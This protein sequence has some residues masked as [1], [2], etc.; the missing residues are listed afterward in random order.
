[1]LL[2]HFLLLVLLP[3]I[4]APSPLLKVS[5]RLIS[6]YL[7]DRIDQFYFSE[8][9]YELINDNFEAPQFRPLPLAD[10]LYIQKTGSMPPNKRLYR[11]MYAITELKIQDV[12]RY[13][14][15]KISHVDASVCPP[16]PTDL[17][18][19]DIAF[20]KFES[21]KVGSPEAALRRL[22]FEPDFVS[23]VI[24]GPFPNLQDSAARLAHLA[25]DPMPLVTKEILLHPHI[26]KLGPAGGRFIMTPERYALLLATFLTRVTSENAVVREV[27]DSLSPSQIAVLATTLLEHRW[28]KGVWSEDALV[29]LSTPN[30]FERLEGLDRKTLLYQLS[31]HIDGPKSFSEMS[32][33]NTF[34]DSLL[35]DL[36]QVHDALDISNGNRLSALG[37]SAIQEKAKSFPLLE[38]LLTPSDNRVGAL[39]Y[40]ISDSILLSHINSEQATK[41]LK[42]LMSIPS[43]ASGLFL[44]QSAIM[45]QVDDAAL[46]QVFDLVHRETSRSYLAV[47]STLAQNHLIP[48]IDGQRWASLL[49]KLV[50]HFSM[51]FYVEPLH[52]SVFFDNALL[53]D[54]MDGHIDQVVETLIENPISDQVMARILQSKF[55]RKL[56]GEQQSRLLIRLTRL[57]YIKS[58]ECLVSLPTSMSDVEK[59]AAY[60]RITSDIQ[61]FTQLS[62]DSRDTVARFLTG[63]TE[64]VQRILPQPVRQALFEKKPKPIQNALV[65]NKPRT[66]PRTSVRL[67]PSSNPL[68]R[69]SP[70][71]SSL[72]SLRVHF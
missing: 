60:S 54:K 9:L 38:L 6:K 68:V 35:H 30:L 65:S 20:I 43:Y 3:V 22:T 10:L 57:G 16:S 4:W 61:V 24:D 2:T 55:A 18:P 32:V 34:A 11:G 25:L 59:K 36:V 52:I 26:A 8:T 63:Q 51:L 15:R 49:A 27:L 14:F 58:I 62:P 5:Y 21:E 12:K 31:K 48:R 23:V 64:F 1:M 69:S 33:E 70:R 56:S 28:A 45:S 44:E 72:G 42:M 67:P 29:L 37:T 47:A 41:I 13:D 50:K 71:M 53:V 39:R 19:K 66:V 17:T 46:N 7:T 40:L